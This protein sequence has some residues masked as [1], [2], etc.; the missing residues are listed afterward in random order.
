MTTRPD[1]PEPPLVSFPLQSAPPPPRLAGAS[2]AALPGVPPP[3]EA[4]PISPV[5]AQPAPPLP[6]ITLVPNVMMSES[7]PAPPFLPDPAAPAPPPP[8]TWQFPTVHPAPPL[9]VPIPPAF[10]FPLTPPTAPALFN[11]ALR[12]VFPPRAV[13]VPRTEDAP[14]APPPCAQ[15]PRRPVASA[16]VIVTLVFA[17][18]LRPVPVNTSPPP[19]P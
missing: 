9:A 18:K 17:V 14:S 3:D 16:T 15:S 12:D 11:T 10:P 5:P 2:H 1:P 19:P 7:T 4:V 13:R 8:P 6:Y